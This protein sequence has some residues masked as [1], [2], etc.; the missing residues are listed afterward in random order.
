MSDVGLEESRNLADTKPEEVVRCG[1]YTL[2]ISRNKLLQANGESVHFTPS[3]FRILVLLARKTGETVT[4]AMIMDHLYGGIDEPEIKIIDI[5]IC[6]IR[7]KIPG[8]PGLIQ[9]VWGRGYRISPG[10]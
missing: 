3:E 9:T 5:F 7:K 4:K 8:P 2:H 6:K 10:H 1:Q